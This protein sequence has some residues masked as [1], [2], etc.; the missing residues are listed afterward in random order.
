MTPYVNVPR[1]PDRHQTFLAGEPT[2]TMVGP[3]EADATNVDTVR[4]RGAMFIPFELVALL[5]DKDLTT[6][7]AFLA[8]YPH[9]EDNYLLDSCR[10]L[11]EFLQV[12]S[13]QPSAGKFSA[14]HPPRPARTSGSS[15]SC[16]CPP[17]APYCCPLPGFT[18]PRPLQPRASSRHLR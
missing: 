4:T 16:G 6:R 11:V 14:S 7:E 2:K 9:L 18:I 15:C 3:F 12:D 13:T 8:V 5:L 10:P 1:M 17:P